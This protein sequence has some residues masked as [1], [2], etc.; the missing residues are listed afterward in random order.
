ML[1]K[2]KN[3]NR[4]FTNWQKGWLYLIAFFVFTFVLDFAILGIEIITTS[5]QLNYVAEKLSFQGGFI[6]GSSSQTY[7][8][9]KDVYDY[10]ARAFARYGVDGTKLHWSLRVQENS[11]KSGT[12]VDTASGTMNLHYVSGGRS[13]TGINSS[14]GV[15]GQLTL[16][17]QH[18]FW[19]SSRVFPFINPINSYSLNQRYQCLYI[20]D[21]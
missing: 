8:S 5:H 17:F 19:F 2:L 11:G 20:N 1:K 12:I 6:G 3:N 14:Y 9:N 21:I 7:W 10:F 16:V 15:S 13:S 4:G 18:R